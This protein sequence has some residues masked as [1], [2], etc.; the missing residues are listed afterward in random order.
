MKNIADLYT[1][2]AASLAQLER[3][4]EKSAA[5]LVQS[6]AKSRDAGL[7]R[8]LFGLGI[9]FVGERAAEL[10]ARRFGSLEALAAASAEEIDAVPEIGEAV[11][12][13][14]LEWFAAPRN[15]ELIGRLKAAGVQL[16]SISS[17]GRDQPR[18]LEGLQFVLTGVLPSMDRNE[19]KR[20]IG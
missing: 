7:Q 11:V 9:R 8:L 16:T 20:L 1:L 18:T 17:R 14:L 5:N 4:G 2:E 10:L 15:R 3:M 6:I 13:S 12:A 19:A